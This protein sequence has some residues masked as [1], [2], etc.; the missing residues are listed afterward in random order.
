MN[1]IQMKQKENL[2]GDSDLWLCQSKTA[3]KNWGVFDSANRSVTSAS[4]GRM[5]VYDQLHESSVSSPTR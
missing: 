4:Q 1:G 2:G 3:I 5:D